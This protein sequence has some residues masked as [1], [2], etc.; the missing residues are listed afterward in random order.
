MA[1][2]VY[3]RDNCHG[4]TT[5]NPVLQVPAV[6]RYP[7]SHALCLPV[8]FKFVRQFK[9]ITIGSVIYIFHFYLQGG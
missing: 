2:T 5:V 7:L 1:A 8:Y 3:E 6:R 4:E 9:V